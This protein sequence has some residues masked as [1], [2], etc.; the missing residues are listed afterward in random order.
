MDQRQRIVAGLIAVTV[1]SLPGVAHADPLVD[2]SPVITEAMGGTDFPTLTADQ[3]AQA[4]LLIQP[5][6]PG[7]DVVDLS[8]P[9]QFAPVVGTLTLDQSVDQGVTDLNNAL[10][11]FL[12]TDT[13]VGVFG[14]SQSALI[15]SDEML[16]LDPSGTPSDLPVSFILLAD[17][18]NPNGGLWERLDGLYI[19]GL[20]VSL[21]GA[22]PS[23]D[24]PTVIYSNEYDLASDFCQYDADV[25]CDINAVMGFAEGQHASIVGLD[26]AVQL[27]TLGAT[28]TTYFMIPDEGI[29]PILQPVADIPVIGTPLVDLLSPDM[30]AIVNWG[31]GNP[32]VGWSEGPANIPTPAT[33]DLPPMEDTTALLSAL[34]EGTQVGI[35]D[36]IAA[37]A[38]S[39]G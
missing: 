9:E 39:V 8:T 11:S 37:L 19:P 26:D 15:A 10:T 22:T 28:E 38:G 36:F 25:V 2:P 18:M 29:L 20:D 23:D 1:V 5:S 27:P 12:D 31:Y 35:Q 3:L 6:L 13:P 34:T 16:A 17:P 32:D 14:V 24:F 7:T 30:T 4:E 33:F 21:N